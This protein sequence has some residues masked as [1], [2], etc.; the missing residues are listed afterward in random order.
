TAK[1]GVII[2]KGGAGI[3]ALKG[4]LTQYISS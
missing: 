1:P 3:E 4:K 2:G